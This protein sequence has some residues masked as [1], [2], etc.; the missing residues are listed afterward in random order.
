MREETVRESEWGKGMRVETVCG[1][2]ARGES[3]WRQEAKVEVE[4]EEKEEWGRSGEEEGE[5]EEQDRGE[6][7]ERITEE[8]RGMYGRG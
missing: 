8:W 5:R 6:R 1:K 4:R 3:E 7:E 2:G